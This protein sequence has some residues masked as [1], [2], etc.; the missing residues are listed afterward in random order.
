MTSPGGEWAKARVGVELDWSNVGGDLRRRLERETAVAS[1]AAQRNFDALSRGAEASFQRMEQAY[2]RQLNQMERATA[3]SVGKIRTELSRLDAD[4]NIRVDVDAAG[5]MRQLRSLH[6]DMQAYLDANPLQVRIDIDRSAI[7]RLTSDISRVRN[8]AGG[9]RSGSNMFSG[10]TSSAASASTTLAKFTAIAGAATIAAGGMLPALAALGAAL[11]A[12]GGAAG[13]AAVAGISAIGLAAGT[14]KTGLGGLGEAFTATSTASAGTAATIVDN[15]KDIADAEYRL[16]QAV[17]NETDAQ[18]DVSR[19]RDDARRKLRD[20]A[21]DLRGMALSEKDAELSLKE[22]REDLRKGDFKTDTER[23]R[24]VL[25]VQE[26]EQRLAEVRRDNNDQAAEAVKTRA[27]GVN[28]DDGVVEAQKRL[29]DATHQ[30]KEAQYAVNE[31]RKPQTTGGSAGGGVDKQAEAMAKLSVNAQEFVRAIMAVKPAWDDMRKSVQDTLFA[32]IAAEVQPLAD[33]Y[34]PLLGD[35]MRGVARG[36]NEGA[37]SAIT[38]VQS[39]TGVRLVTDILKGSSN[40]ASNFGK[41]LG[42]LVPGLAAIGASANNVFSPLSNGLAGAAKSLSDFLLEAQQTGQMDRFFQNAIAVARQLGAVFVQLGGIIGGVMR[43]AAAASGGNFLG[44][45]T[46]SLTLIN[47][48]VN[49][50]G[51]AALTSFFTSMQGAI[52]AVVPILLQLAGIIGTTVAPA[53]SGLIQ[54]IAPSIGTL[55]DSLGQGLTNLAPAMKPLGDAINSIAAALGPVLPVLGTLIAQVAQFAGP[56]LGALATALSPILVAIGNSLI[57]AFQALQPAVAP[58]SNLLVALAPI[59]AQI[60]VALGNALVTSLK[61]VVPVFNVLVGILIAAAPAVTGLVEMLTPLASIIAGVATALALA[62][63]AFKVFQAAQAIIAGVRTA[64]MLLSLA[65]SISPIGM[66]VTLVAALVAGLVLFFTKTELGQRIWSAAWN[67]IKSAFS[68]VWNFIVGNWS[69]ILMVLTGP[70]GVAVGMI[71][72]N[73]DTIK[74]AAG[75]AKDWIVSRWDELV[76][77]LR[78]MPGRVT[79]ALSGL[80]NGLKDMFRSAINWVIQKW[81]DFE[82]S[83]KMPSWLGGKTVSIGTPNIPLF[84]TGGTVPMMPGA[85]RGKDSILAGIMPGEFI[86]P[87]RGVTAQTLPFLEALRSGWKPSKAF[88]AALPGFAGGGTVGG[89]EPYGLPIG[90]NTGGYG[91]SGTVFPQWVHDIEKRFNVKASTY[92]G[93]QEKSGLN[94]GIDWSGSVADMQR[95]AEFLKSDARELEQVIW[96]NPETGEKIG[97]ADGKLVGPGTD[98]PGYYRDD[99]ADHTNHVHTRQSYSFGGSAATGNAPGINNTPGGT[100][101]TSLSAGAATPIGSGIGSEG[102]GTSGTGG[103]SPSWG[104]SGG[105]SQFNSAAEADKAGV[106]PVWVE[107]WPATMGGGSAA[108]AA[109]LDAATPAPP[110]APAPAPSGVDTI[111]LKKNPDGTYTST[112]PEWA[113]LIARESGGRPKVVQGIQDVNSGGNEASG[114]FQIAKGTWAGYGGTK[115]APSAGEATPE[116]QAEIAAKIFNKEGGSPWGSGAGQNFGRENEGRLRAG[117]KRRSIPAPPA[118]KPVAPPPADTTPKSLVPATPQAEQQGQRDLKNER[119]HLDDEGDQLKKD[120]PLKPEE[121]RAAV[122]LLGSGT[123]S[124]H[125]GTLGGGLT[126]MGVNNLIDS[127]PKGLFGKYDDRDEKHPSLGS[128][129]GSVV[130]AF[131]SGQVS[132]GLGIVGLDTEPSILSAIGAYNQ[133]NQKSSGDAATKKDLGDLVRDLATNGLGAVTVNIFGNAD[134]NQVARKVDDARRRKM[135]RYANT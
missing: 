121:P 41:A 53:L 87:T 110:A 113:R 48:W 95:L 77:F 134:G 115:F 73:W 108:P 10:I 99:W 89:R 4:L 55:V 128:R 24:A 76:G 8:S 75:A 60:A 25:R 116:Q 71:V 29:A 47:N 131:L 64:W 98:Q 42:N 93:H 44:G 11:A 52:K 118:P 14:L 130:D 5:A 56:I 91:S 54:Q 135:R 88:L 28:G 101:T 31:A 67:G 30:V 123:W 49:G 72:K 39:A 104:N 12:V 20:L 27:K 2:D 16:K 6:G 33:R 15:T 59:L 124:Q 66:V 34:I 83:I 26:A 102:S 43:A 82:L 109:S 86:V 120:I 69:T 19:A 103:S 13:G 94:K 68:A 46:N 112:D 62:Y 97:V 3:R 129:A 1:R 50:P 61:M 84:G 96:M 35:A 127:A 57:S 111:P 107:N 133:D 81:N 74:N 9:G 32:G 85:K 36:F 122:D 78:G 105:G 117:I 23:E 40:T 80:W 21:L 79:K 63:G 65:F 58:I 92:A 51:S 37:R 106:V 38:F 90:T 70:I 114:L 22:A 45:L 126:Q 125:A 7:R 132:S 17:E 119:K 18:K 100:S